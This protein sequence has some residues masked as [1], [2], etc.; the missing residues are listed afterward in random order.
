M[1]SHSLADI[2]HVVVETTLARFTLA[3]TTSVQALEW[4]FFLLS[5]GD[6]VQPWLAIFVDPLAITN[7][8]FVVFLGSHHMIDHELHNVDRPPVVTEIRT[9]GANIGY[10][11][12]VVAANIHTSNIFKALRRV[13][14][15]PAV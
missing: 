7:I 13:G 1:F 10:R 8:S 4:A 3:I 5:A 2:R 6:Y 12:L 9:A 14:W 11:S 15:K